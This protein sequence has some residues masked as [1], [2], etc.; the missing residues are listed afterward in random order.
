MV[1]D[2]LKK[3]QDAE[4]EADNIIFHANE[5]AKNILKRMELKI[6]E[7]GEKII[8]EI[9]KEL[10][11][12]KKTVIDEAERDVY[13][14]YENEKKYIDNIQNIDDDKVFEVVNIFKERIV[15]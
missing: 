8:N 7:D 6:K 13:L 15:K 9:Q 2:I 12:L 10:E 3:I 4:T 11:N 14:A 5:E 1:D